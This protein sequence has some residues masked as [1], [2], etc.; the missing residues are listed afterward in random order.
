MLDAVNDPKDKS[1]TA[2]LTAVT[3]SVLKAISVVEAAVEPAAPVVAA[4]KRDKL[5]VTQLNEAVTRG[6]LLLGHFSENY[7]SH[8]MRQV[9][10]EI[11]KVH[12]KRCKMPTTHCYSVEEKKRRT[13]LIP[14]GEKSWVTH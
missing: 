2:Q 1:K 10:L 13:R 9:N 4:A 6:S 12:L 3:E 7:F 8:D 5:K 14:R 11:L